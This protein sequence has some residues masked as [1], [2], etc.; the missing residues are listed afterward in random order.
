M[1]SARIHCA[2]DFTLIESR[3]NDLGWDNTSFVTEIGIHPRD[4]QRVL[5]PERVTLTWL[6]D[7]ATALGVHPADLITS[8]C[9]STEV[10]LGTDSD[11][12]ET[13][14]VPRSRP[15][16]VSAETLSI[17]TGWPLQRVYAALEALQQHLQHT[18][19][20][21]IRDSRGYVIAS[22][23]PS[24][25]AGDSLPGIRRCANP[26][27]LDSAGLIVAA[28]HAHAPP[29]TCGQLQPPPGHA[30]SHPPQP[31]PP[32]RDTD[33]PDGYLTPTGLHPDMLFALLLTDAPA[34]A[35][36]AVTGQ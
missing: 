9:G 13:L 17:I 4:L 18:P 36:P 15:A 6:S 19:F 12:I 24:P 5:A 32:T 26:L 11:I 10:E 27:T 7:I 3:A 16:A 30:T 1:T 14:L 35:P 28:V 31:D 33:G 8:S 22:R 20:V 34:P 25:Q 21:L 23:S 2:L 29:T